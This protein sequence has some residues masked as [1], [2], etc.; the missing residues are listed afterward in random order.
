MTAN[1]STPPTAQTATPTAVLSILFVLPAFPSFQ[2]SPS[3]TGLKGTSTAALA[4]APTALH[5]S[6]GLGQRRGGIV[7][8]RVRAEDIPQAPG[9]A[10]EGGERHM[11]R[12]LG[13]HGRVVAGGRGGAD[14]HDTEAVHV[15]DGQH[16][17]LDQH[18]RTCPER[19]K[20]RREF[21]NDDSKGRCHE[22]KTLSLSSQQ[23]HNQQKI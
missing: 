20:G 9:V 1:S 17:Q 10:H 8:Q 6:R 7:G 18:Q 12:V 23:T 21:Q 5:L 19:M 22:S 11:L 16:H 2:H 4:I 13:L 15:E 3:F 14:L